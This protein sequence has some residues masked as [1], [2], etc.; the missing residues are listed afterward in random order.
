M[1]EKLRYLLLGI[2]VG[3][4]IMGLT[5]GLLTDCKFKS[6]KVQND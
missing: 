1:S 5:T 4:W 6:A 3:V 2:F